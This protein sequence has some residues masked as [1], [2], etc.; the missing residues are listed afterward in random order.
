MVLDRNTQRHLELV[1]NQEDLSSKAT[2]FDVLDR[3]KTPM[4]K[5]KL[6][7]WILNPL[8]DIKN[9]NNRLD[10]VDYFFTETNKRKGIRK[11][12]DDIYDVERLANKTSMGT[13]NPRD[14]MA[15]SFSLKGIETLKNIIMEN[16]PLP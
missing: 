3:T 12:L 1:K 8:L 15:L 16:L 4:G 11:L 13:A 9:I 10:I 7:K 6:K 2:L 14:L 5:R